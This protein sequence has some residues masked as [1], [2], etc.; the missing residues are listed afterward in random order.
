MPRPTS[1]VSPPLVSTIGEAIGPPGPPGVGVAGISKH[2]KSIV[3]G[4]EN[5]QSIGFQS[6]GT[7]TLIDP[8][9]FPSGTYTWEAVIETTNA[10]DGAEIRLFNITLGSPVAGTVL[11]TTNLI[12][13]HLS[14]II[15]LATGQNLYSAQLRL[16]TTG[17]PNTATCR[18]AQISIN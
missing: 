12:P 5:T 11:S 8:A 9:D 6:I 2:E 15:S 10:A 16:Q 13:T 7:S 1:L 18:Q 17:F 3:A 14:A 4:V